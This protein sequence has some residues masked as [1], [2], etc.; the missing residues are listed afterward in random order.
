[1][2]SRGPADIVAVTSTIESPHRT[3]TAPSAC[4]ARRPVSRESVFP[5]TSSETR[6][7]RTSVTSVAIQASSSSACGNGAPGAEYTLPPGGAR[8]VPAA[9]LPAQPEP[10]HDRAVAREVVGAQVGQ[11]TAPLADHFE[12]APAGVEI[13]L[14]NAQVLAEMVDALGQPGDLD[15]RRSA[16]G[17]VAPELVDGNPG[18]ARGLRAHTCSTSIK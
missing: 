14:M 5:P 2:P 8:P 6:P 16:V 17:R 4:R 15:V 13:L 3:T 10:L 7:V 1:M 9:W 11:E 12:Q 18:A